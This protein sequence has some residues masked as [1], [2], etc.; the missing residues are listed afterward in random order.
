MTD[1]PDSGAP[2]S[3]DRSGEELDRRTVVRGACLAGLGVVGAAALSGCGSAS[4]GKPAAHVFDGSAVPVG[5]GLISARDLVVVTQPTRGEF[6]GF[7]AVCP[8]QG[9][10]VTNVAEGT[11]NCPCH[12]SKFSV[13][14]GAV[15]L[16]PAT[17]PLPSLPVS[18]KGGKVTVN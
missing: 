10:T 6:K 12:G 14:N 18:V 17:T 3:V 15:K 7:S 5:G 8:H 9:C 1:S 11:I 4:S 16:G 13:S 2:G